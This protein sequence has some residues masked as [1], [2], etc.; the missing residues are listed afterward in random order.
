MHA[1]L[2]LPGVTDDIAC[3][4]ARRYLYDPSVRYVLGAGG[5][6]PTAG[7]PVAAHWKSRIVGVDCIGWALWCW[8]IARLQP[9][10][11][12]YGG[13]INCDS[14]IID[15]RHAA[16]WF[17]LLERPERGALLVWPSI[18]IDH[19]GDRD[20][21]GHVSMI[22]DPLPAEWSPATSR[23]AELTV[24][25]CGAS[26][27]HLA[28]ANVRNDAIRAPAVALTTGAA[29]DHREHFTYAGKEHAE[30]KWRSVMLRVKR[31]A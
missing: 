16:V 9:T 26:N 24:A 27:S 3:A 18:D 12:E 13:Y 19:D 1:P 17:E 31:P 28:P 2:L 21:I 10:F 23:F 30:P 25:H 6:D 7:T 11:P 29:W 14:A 5:V 8:G 22:L 15:A 4:R 20:R